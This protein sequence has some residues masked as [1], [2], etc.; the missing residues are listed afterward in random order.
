MK[1]S[2]AKLMAIEQREIA[3]LGPADPHRI[4]KHNFEHWR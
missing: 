3:D 4:L 2:D 1:C